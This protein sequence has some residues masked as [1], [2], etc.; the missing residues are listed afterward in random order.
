MHV[1]ARTALKHSQYH[2]DQNHILDN[3]LLFPSVPATGAM[4]ATTFCSDTESL[5]WQQDV[6]GSDIAWNDILLQKVLVGTTDGWIK[7]LVKDVVNDWS[8]GSL[9]EQRFNL[10]NVDHTATLTV[11]HELTHSTAMGPGKEIRM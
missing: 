7:G 4:L 10:L 1:S 5:L 11:M 9:T 8:I 2:L 6:I 3:K